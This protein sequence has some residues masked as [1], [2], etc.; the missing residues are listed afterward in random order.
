MLLLFSLLE[1][2][3]TRLTGGFV[4]GFAAVFATIGFVA[5]FATIGFVAVFVAV[6][7]TETRTGDGTFLIGATAKGS[8]SRLESDILLME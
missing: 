8:F 3:I 2:A 7:A 6:F 4:A 5:V 1:K